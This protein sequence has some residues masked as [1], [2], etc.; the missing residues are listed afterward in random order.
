[1]S[2]TGDSLE[3]IQARRKRIDAEEEFENQVKEDDELDFEDPALV[4]ARAL[5]LL[6]KGE[7]IKVASSPV[8]EDATPSELDKVARKGA[9]IKTIKK[10]AKVDLKSLPSGKV[11]NIRIFDQSLLNDNLEGVDGESG[12]AM[13]ATLLWVPSKTEV[14]LPAK[15]LQFE[16]GICA[17]KILGGDVNTF[18]VDEFEFIFIGIRLL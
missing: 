8:E 6:R 13:A 18:I 16:H 4:S 5:Q 3:I 15:V 2:L 14:W 10:V 9:T 12:G 7:K 11:T 1:M 17:F